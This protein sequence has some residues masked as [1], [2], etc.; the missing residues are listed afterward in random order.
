LIARYG[1]Q[2]VFMDLTGI[3]YGADFRQHILDAWQ[4]AHVLIAVIGSGWLGE[5]RDGPP[6]IRD[7]I[8]PIRVE[9]ETALRQGITI[10]PAL[11]DGAKMPAAQLL[12]RSMSELVYRNAM[13]I[14]S[15]LDF[16]PHIQRL[17][18]AIDQSLGIESASAQIQSG[19]AAAAP[20]KPEA[21]FHAALAWCGRLWPYFLVPVILLLL[22]HYLIE[23]TWDLDTIYLRPFAVIVPLVTGYLLQRKIRL[24][25][26]A[27]TLLGLLVALA[28]VPAMMTVVGLIDHHA[29]L[30]TTAAGWREP[31]EFAVTIT[32]AAGAGNL[33]ARVISPVMLGGWRLF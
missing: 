4:G 3:P 1:A 25:A 13:P 15:G 12:P 32:L 28:A 17:L 21:V 16:E 24:G 29:I 31:V 6:R 2:A 26:A 33:L 20:K 27:A 18:T 19:S 23:M 22:A 5:Q 14:D 7:K 30:P 11:I 9:I 10:I 8:D